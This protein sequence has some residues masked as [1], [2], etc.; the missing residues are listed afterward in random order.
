MAVE[1]C[2]KALYTSEISDHAPVGMA[3]IFRAAHCSEDSLIT[4]EHTKHFLYRH[5]VS[6]YIW[7]E[8]YT[9]LVFEDD[10]QKLSYLKNIMRAASILVREYM[11]SMDPRSPVFFSQTL[12][13][14]AR[15]VWNQSET[16]FET[17]QAY[18]SVADNT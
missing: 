13:A 5:Y 12:S 2:P 11:Q 15:A 17:L 14:I 3:I 10:F 9:Q 4:P 16:L 8:Q 7:E 6:Y 18:S 1:Q